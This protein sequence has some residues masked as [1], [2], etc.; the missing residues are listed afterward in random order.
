MY[1]NCV[2]INIVGDIIEGGFNMLG[3]KRK[4]IGVFATQ[5]HREFQ[6]LLCRG[7][8]SRAYDLGYN[9]AIFSNYMGYNELIYEIGERDIA[10]LPI[11]EDLDGIV[12]VPDTINDFIINVTDNIKRF[13]NCPVVS[14]KENMSEYYNVLFEE[15]TALDDIIHHFINHHKFTK[16][17]FLTGPRDNLVSDQRLSAYRRILAEYDI[18][19]EEERIYYGDF[20]KDAA[21]DAVESWFVD[22]EKRPQAIIC[23]NDFMAISVCN[24]LAKR[25]ILVPQDIAVTGCDNISISMDF[26]PAITTVGMPVFDM[27]MMA[28]DKIHMHNQGISQEGISY[29]KSITYIRESCGCKTKDSAENV[30]RRRNHLIDTV[31]DKDKSIFNNANMSISLTGTTTLDDLR[32]KLSKYI[33]LNEGFSSFYMCLFSEWDRDKDKVNMWMD[34]DVTMEVGIKNGTL[35]KKVDYNIKNLLPAIYMDE[36]PQFYYFNMLHHQ[37]KCYGFTAIS[38]ERF[39]AYK[40]S[41]QGWLINVCNA[42]ENIKTHNALNRLV[43]KLEDMSIKDELTGLYNRRALHTLGQKYLDQSIKNHS[44]LMVFSADMDNMKY[45]NDNYG[46]SKGDIAIKVVADSLMDASEDDEICI[47]MGGDEYSVIGVE[48]D[49]NKMSGFVKKFEDSIKKFNQDPAYDFMISI[50]YGWSVTQANKDTDLE[51]CLS[52]ADRKMY[53]QKYEKAEKRFKQMETRKD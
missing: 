19:I 24:A 35:L 51:E 38:F 9:V 8:C 10:N 28:V 16:I 44:S 50:S 34:K 25:G 15:D 1:Y 14:V 11:Y 26:T 31:E 42:L 7:I 12:I 21:E 47:R 41:Y 3:N 46:H 2:K 48:Y 37:E 17:N 23:A 18:L 40:P 20:W 32:S 36:E 33:Y 13:S 4:T 39:Q 43:Y 52:L 53:Q 29:L 45:I 22:S 49:N 27:G 5:I 6:D 30:L